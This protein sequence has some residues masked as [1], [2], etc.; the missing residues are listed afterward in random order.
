MIKKWMMALAMT[1]VG[2]AAFAQSATIEPFK[3]GDRICF[4]GNSITEAG[5]YESYIW[6]YYMLH[7]PSRP[8]RI[9]NIGIGGD[10]AF[11]MV[12]RFEDD[13]IPHK[14]TVVCLTFGMNDSGYY[15]W[16]NPKSDSIG[17]AKIAESEHYFT[18]LEDKLKAMPNVRK[19]MIGTSPYDE[20]MKN[21][22]NY[23]P[24]KSQAMEQIVAYQHQ[25]AINHHWDFVD[26]FHPMTEINIREQAKDSTFTLTGNDRIHPGNAGHMVMAYLFLK[27]QGLG[28][29]PVADVEIDAPGSTLRKA[30]N[31]KVSGLAATASAVQFNYLANSLPFPVDTISRLWDN[32][33]PQSGAVKV[34]PF[35]QEFNKEILTVKGLGEGTYE[36]KIDSVV[37]GK[38]TSTQLAAGINLAAEPSTPEYEQAMSVL[39]LNEERMQLESKVRQYYW[40]QFNYLTDKGLRFNDNRAA[41]DSVLKESQTNWFVASKRDN[42]REARY[43]AVR[44]AWQ[45]QMDL[46]IEEIYSI[47]QPK[48]HKVTLREL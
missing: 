42:Y 29:K 33:R 37:I 19:I 32:P 17:K 5:Y 38:W 10:R 15:E 1:T 13:I 14:P 35:Y 18:I 22:K 21:P 47:N 23:F 44:E 30:E 41:I 24:K 25:A 46:L 3:K 16:L 20:T 7:F 48:E 28:N 4:M 36:L 40:L 12:G 9:Y 31:C 39:W 27:D 2:S 11:N 34:I 43:A 8:I 6:L 26:F 45:K